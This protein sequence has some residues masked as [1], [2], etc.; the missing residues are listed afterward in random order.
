VQPIV[1]NGK[2]ISDGHAKTGIVDLKRS[3]SVCHKC[4]LVRNSNNQVERPD[5]RR[6]AAILRTEATVESDSMLARMEICPLG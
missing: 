5:E 2:K 1:G 6:S 4:T 3:V